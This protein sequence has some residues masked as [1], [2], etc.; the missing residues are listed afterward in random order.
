[1]RMRREMFYSAD[2]SLQT[3]LI[4]ISQTENNL[5]R[6][7]EQRI[8]LLYKFLISHYKKGEQLSIMKRT[9]SIPFR[10]RKKTHEKR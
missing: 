5:N 6:S 1:M 2:S 3:N 9:L 4:L 7:V 10:K 8:V